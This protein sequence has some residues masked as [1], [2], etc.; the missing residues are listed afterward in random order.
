MAKME[1]KGYGKGK[2][3][4]LECETGSVA[5]F[6]EKSGGPVNPYGEVAK[7]ESSAINMNA[8]EAFNKKKL[9]KIEVMGTEAP[10]QSGSQV[11]GKTGFKTEVANESIS[12]GGT[13][14]G[15]KQSFQTV[16]RK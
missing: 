16:K 7:K 15:K 6:V 1:F 3:E 4:F 5:G 2:E 13:D 12:P 11:S 8:G 9:D 10:K 14:C